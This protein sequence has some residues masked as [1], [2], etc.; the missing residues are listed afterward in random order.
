VAVKR[1]VGLAKNP[2]LWHRYLIACTG[3]VFVYDVW[4]IK[5]GRKQLEIV[6]DYLDLNEQSDQ[7]Q[8]IATAMDEVTK[9]S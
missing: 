5:Q 3:R 9:Q 6:L 8:T 4:T 2:R 1:G 7:Q